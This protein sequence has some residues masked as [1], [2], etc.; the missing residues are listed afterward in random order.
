MFAKLLFRSALLLLPT[1]VFALDNEVLDI[2]ALDGG[3]SRA[4]S[5]NNTGQLLG[6]STYTDSVGRAF[7][8]PVLFTAN[9]GLQWIVDGGAPEEINDAGEVAFATNTWK[10]GVFTSVNPSCFTSYFL[11]GRCFS[12]NNDSSDLVGATAALVDDGQGGQRV[13]TF[14]FTQ[15]NG[16]RESFGAGS[17]IYDVNNHGQLVGKNLPASNPLV[18]TAPEGLLKAIN[19]ASVAAGERETADE[20]QAFLFVGDAVNPLGKIGAPGDASTVSGLN[21]WGQVVGTATAFT[22]DAR[23]F[24]YDPRV[25]IRDLN[26]F[27]PAG[28][29][30]VL[31]SALRINNRGEIA[32][33]GVHNGIERGYL[34][35][36]RDLLLDPPAPPPPVANS[37]GLAL[38][39]KCLKLRKVSLCAAYVGIHDAALRSLMTFPFKIQG[40][41]KKKGPWVDLTPVMTGSAGFGVQQL[42]FYTSRKYVRAVA[43]TELNGTG[44]PLVSSVR[45]VKT[46][47]KAVLP[48]FQ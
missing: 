13:E 18:I 41:K 46:S 26:D 28:S 34:F 15:R 25:G 14:A 22:G 40:A 27:L 45:T 3:T 33:T 16:V 39:G 30:W 2:G 9:G 10:D 7:E 11:Y 5:L 21:I 1:T 17:L 36:L 4:V 48:T 38:T 35:V 37:I 6:V 29:G 47:R 31:K 44:L 43:T 20:K 32:G 12:G 42:Y 23:A 19:N 8:V 24:F